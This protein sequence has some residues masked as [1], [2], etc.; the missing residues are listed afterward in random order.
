MDLFP[1]ATLTVLLLIKEMGVPVPV[2]GDLLVLGAGAATSGRPEALVWLLSILVAGYIGGAIQ[3]LLVRGAMRGPLLALLARLGVP[4]ARLDGL[5]AALKAGGPRAMALA[6]AT[7]GLRVGSIAAGGIADLPLSTFLPGFLIG[8]TVFVGG[9]FALG[10][11]VGK[12]ALGIAADLGKPVVLAAIPVA[13][14]LAGAVAWF[15]IRRRTGAGAARA[16]A[17]SGVAAGGARTGAAVGAGSGAAAGNSDAA[18]FRRDAHDGNDAGFGAWAD[19]ACPICI[20]LGAIRA[21]R[22]A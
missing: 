14:S 1:L 13:F 17:A 7:P 6:R 11:V 22:A 12:P 16:E 2:P 9:H 8:N 5:A 19:A 18:P 21:A 20:A 15:V 3:F 10:F 4:Q